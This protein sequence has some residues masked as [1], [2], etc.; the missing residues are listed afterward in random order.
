MTAA[1]HRLHPPRTAT[2]RSSASP[3]RRRRRCFGFLQKD[4]AA[5]ASVRARHRRRH[6]QP[7]S[8]GVGARRRSSIR[9]CRTTTRAT[10]P[11]WCRSAAAPSAASSSCPK[12]TTKCWSGSRWATCASPYVL[13]G[14]WNGRD[15]PPKKNRDVIVSGGKVQKR[16]IRSRSGHSVVLDDS[17]RRRQHHHRGQ[18]RQQDEV[19]QCEQRAGHRRQRQ[20]DDRGQG[21]ALD[22]GGRSADDSRAPIIKLN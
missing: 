22:Q 11:G 7:G 18:E 19:R 6:R 12:S 9:G 4:E 5:R 10:G 13:G 17:R 14:L 15:L 8:D 16:I 3:V 20:S 21:H 1:T 2:R